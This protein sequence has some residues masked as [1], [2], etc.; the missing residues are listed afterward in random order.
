LELPD[1]WLPRPGDEPSPEVRAAFDAI[2]RRTLDKGRSPL[3]AEPLPA[4]KWQFLCHLADEHGLVLH[5]SGRPDI[6]VFEPRQPVDLREFGSRN[7]VYAAGD[8][9]WAM[10]YAVANRGRIP[11]MTNA[12]VRLV[13]PAGHASPPR[14]V[15]SISRST[16]AEEAWRSGTVYILPGE[17]FE[18]QPPLEFGQ[19]E[20][21]IPQLASP[22]AVHPL[23][24]VRVEPADFPF[25]AQVR[26]HD[27]DR[28]EEY[29]RA[30]ETG[31]PWP[32]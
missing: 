9:L 3:L 13:D 11:T 5:G 15:F 28:L 12:C 4:P 10:F 32:D 29:T 25:L 8:G 30:L 14:Y 26:V 24:R 27:D 16:A 2:W 22:I 18:L 7:A 17:P 31:A 23:A 1:Y 21:H 6:A 19:Y 20:A